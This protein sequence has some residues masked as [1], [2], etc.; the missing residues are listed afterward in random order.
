MKKTELELRYN[1]ETKEFTMV[2]HGIIVYLNTEDAMSISSS[3]FK[4]IK[5]EELNN[6]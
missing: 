5:G 1:K 6:A 3:I 4:I 2:V